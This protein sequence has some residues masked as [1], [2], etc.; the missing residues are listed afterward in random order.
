MVKKETV[1]TKQ[2]PMV[3]PAAHCAANGDNGTGISNSN[4]LYKKPNNPNN[5]T[6]ITVVGL[7]QSNCWEPPPPP[8]P[9]PTP[10]FQNYT[11]EQK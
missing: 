11:I 9:T 4:V 2:S 7:R 1:K 3:L 5:K 6:S 8:T 10:Q